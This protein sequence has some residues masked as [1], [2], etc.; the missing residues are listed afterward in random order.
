MPSYAIVGA[1]RGLGY[2]WL[3]YLSRDPANTVIGLARTPSTVETRLSADNI[4]NV[5]IL[6]GDMVSQTSLVSAAELAT[7]LLP[8]GLDV[9]IINGA[10][11]NPTLAFRTASS[12][13]S[14]TEAEALKRDMHASLDVNV[15]GVLYSINAFLHLIL[16]G[17]LKKIIVISTGLADPDN[18]IAGDGNPLFVTYASMKAALNMV[19][20]KFAAELKPKDVKVLALSPGVVQTKET[21]PTEQEIAQYTAMVKKFQERA[22]HWKGPLTPLESVEHQL[23]V[24]DGLTIEDSGKFLSHWGDKN[25]L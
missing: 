6:P 23:K 19:V 9:L 3:Q 7:T 22:P 21:P 13:S 10:H 16:K 24:I 17:R 20:A 25:W 2:A 15:L 4:T 5:H 14:S 8:S 18:A 11:N 12:F 1:S